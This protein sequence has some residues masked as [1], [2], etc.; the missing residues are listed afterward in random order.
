MGI[1]YMLAMQDWLFRPTCCTHQLCTI[2][3]VHIHAGDTGGS[4]TAAAA[5]GSA[6]PGVAV[7]GESLSIKGLR[8]GS[9]LMLVFELYCAKPSVAGLPTK[10]L[11]V[12]WAAT[13]LLQ[14]GQVSGVTT[15]VAERSRGA[16]VRDKR[17]TR[18]RGSEQ[19][20]QPSHGPAD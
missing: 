18:L 9:S 7:F 6:Q 10:E 13:P 4:S 5:G 2:V 1:F 20:P 3:H 17:I 15:L 12:A 16:V 14:G 11:L 19:W 8:L